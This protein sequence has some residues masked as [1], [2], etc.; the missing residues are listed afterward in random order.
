MCVSLERSYFR[1]KGGPHMGFETD[2]IA[3]DRG[4]ARS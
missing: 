4:E 2:L 3:E 1:P